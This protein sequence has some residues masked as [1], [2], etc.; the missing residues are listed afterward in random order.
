MAFAL[1]ALVLSSLTWSM[2]W[3]RLWGFERRS[4]KISRAIGVIVSGSV[5]SVIWIVGLVLAKGKDGK[6]DPLDWA[7][8]DVVYALG[9]VKLVVTVVK[10]IP[11]AWANYKRQST[12][13]WSINQIL[14]DLLGGI[15]SIAQLLIDSSLQSDWSGITGNS[16][17]LGLGNVS[18][19]FDVMFMVQHY[20]LYRSKD[21][22]EEDGT[23]VERRGLLS[24]DDEEHDRNNSE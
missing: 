23:D 14:M 22:A 4:W 7:W 1:H 21:R 5:V 2:F 10:Y 12:I 8:I 13:G 19:I 20:F 11:Q 17:K 16:V 6:Y 24:R 18:I 9:Y 3:P 15:L